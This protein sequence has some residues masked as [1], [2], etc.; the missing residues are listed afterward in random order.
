MYILLCHPVQRRGLRPS[1]GGPA[2]STAP[3]QA[4]QGFCLAALE[5]KGAEAKGSAPGS[6]VVLE[7][8]G[9]TETEPAMACLLV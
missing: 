4:R 9:T 3:A 6:S 8:S 2:G 5:G 7:D 1:R